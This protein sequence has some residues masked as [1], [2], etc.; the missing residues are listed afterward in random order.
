MIRK[1]F[2]KNIGFVSKRLIVSPFDSTSVD[3]QKD[4]FS[5][6]MPKFKTN[7]SA[8]RR[9]NSIKK[10]VSTAKECQFYILAFNNINKE[11]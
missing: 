11:Q 8:W 6:T 4:K 9:K 2:G 5:Y 10:Y 1:N 3:F 7:I